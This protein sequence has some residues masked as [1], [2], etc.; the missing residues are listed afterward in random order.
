ME[1][2]NLDHKRMGYVL[3]AI[4]EFCD[5]DE[6]GFST[7][8]LDQLYC[9]VDY[10][11]EYP[12]RIHHPLED[13]VFAR[14]L[15]KRTKQ[16]NK[17]LVTA[18][19]NQH[20]ELAAQ[21][22]QLLAMLP[23]KKIAHA[24]LLDALRH[25]VKRQRQHMQH[26]HDAVFPLAQDILSAKDWA[27]IEDEFDASADPLYDLEEDRFESIFHYTIQDQTYGSREHRGPSNPRPAQPMS[28]ASVSETT[29]AGI[30]SSAGSLFELAENLAAIQ[31]EQFELLIADTTQSMEEL[32]SRPPHEVWMNYF[33]KRIAHQ[34]EGY[35]EFWRVLMAEAEQWQGE[36][37]R[38][39]RR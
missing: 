20:Q 8:S 34:T 22:T 21:T 16:E 31:R 38:I 1:R 35:A 25:Y 12:D 4:E 3:R 32:G 30:A 5:K 11:A 37:T 28:L 23:D 19:Q 6:A 33:S 24:K 36:Q 14:I 26:E 18:N 29:G 9:L 15:S 17:N 2:L 13:Q 39:W 27:A 10:V 7:T